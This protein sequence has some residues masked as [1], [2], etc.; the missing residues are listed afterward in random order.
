MGLV[1]HWITSNPIT[2]S[3]TS[4]LAWSS[5]KIQWSRKQS[6]ICLVALSIATH[7]WWA[8]ITE[9]R[10]LKTCFPDREI[11]DGRET[12]RPENTNTSATSVKRANRKTFTVKIITQLFSVMLD[13]PLL[14]CVRLLDRLYVRHI[15]KYT[16]RLNRFLRVHWHGFQCK[17]YQRHYVCHV[18]LLFKQ[19]FKTA[20]AVAAA[21]PE[22]ILSFPKE[23]FLDV[24]KFS[25]KFRASNKSSCSSSSAVSKR[26][27]SLWGG[28]DCSQLFRMNSF[29]ELFV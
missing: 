17:T 11:L 2:R 4:C 28:L 25:A 26:W 19:H 18:L 21:S 14:V 13:A 16:K 20:A 3:L 5:E 12:L 29:R 10:P 15:T 23:C 24:I 27:E 7:V 6:A 8:K 22:Q 9:A 1:T